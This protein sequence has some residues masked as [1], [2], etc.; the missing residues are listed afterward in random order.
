MTGSAA[1][2]T[3]LGI[4]P[5]PADLIGDTIAQNIAGVGTAQAGAA[6]L[7]G[8]V[9]TVTTAGGAT[10]FILKAHNPGRSVT[11]WNQSA[12]AAL[13]YPPTGAAI[14]GGGANASFSVAQNKPAVFYFVTPLIIFAE[15][16][17]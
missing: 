16:S 15:L 8:T 2:L 5:A 12:T 13:V 9:N 14:N 4:P 17:A 11:V 3:A 7:T 10:A 1:A 6:L